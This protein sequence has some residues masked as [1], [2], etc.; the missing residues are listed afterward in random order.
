MSS[1]GLEIPKASTKRRK[2]TTKT[3]AA[4]P[5]YQEIAKLAQR[6]WDD[7]GRPEGS[8]EQDW[9]RAEKDLLE[10]AS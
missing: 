6:Y 10:H 1:K 8:P 2:A 4:P 5:S 3:P 7:R 9:L